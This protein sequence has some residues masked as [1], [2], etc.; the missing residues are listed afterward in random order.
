MNKHPLEQL[1]T[2]YLAEKDI[3]K[4]SYD[5]Y[6]TILRQ[7]V[8]YLNEH[9]IT[10]AT[11]QDVIDY[12]G[13]KQSQGYSQ[14]WIYHQISAIKGLYSFLSLNQK[15]LDL[16]HEYDV[17]I[18]K[19]IKNIKIHQQAPKSILSTEQAKQ[20]ILKTKENRK[21]IWHYRDHAIIYLMLTT[22][23]RGIEMRRAMRKDLR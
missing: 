9:D 22:G 21:Y 5:L 4:E 7:Y 23:L 3:T 1:I 19:S 18:T 2:E 17:D 6:D 20:L 13:M 16:P 12:I 14:R 10:Y 15:R 8:T 11:T